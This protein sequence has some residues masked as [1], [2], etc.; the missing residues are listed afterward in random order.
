MHLGKIPTLIKTLENIMKML[1]SPFYALYKQISP[2]NRVKRK[3]KLDITPPP[4]HH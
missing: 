2:Y 1:R 3:H 4:S